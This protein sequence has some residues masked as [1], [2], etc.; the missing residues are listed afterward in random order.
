MEKRCFDVNALAFQRSL[1]WKSW[2][3]FFLLLFQESTIDL[4]R[5]LYHPVH[6]LHSSSYRVV[7]KLFR[8]SLSHILEARSNKFFL[9]FI[10]AI[11]I[12]IFCFVSG[13]LDV[14]AL[15]SSKI[16]KPILL[17]FYRFLFPLTVWCSSCNLMP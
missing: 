15:H 9:F 6:L 3:Y 7:F 1:Q 17:L 13:F 12:F 5:R 11:I 10:Y 14:F 2:S 16:F 4:F 8:Y